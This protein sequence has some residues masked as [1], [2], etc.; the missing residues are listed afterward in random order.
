MTLSKVCSSA[1]P[2]TPTP[3]GESHPLRY[4]SIPKTLLRSATARAVRSGRAAGGASS[5]VQTHESPLRLLAQAPLVRVGGSKPR[6]GP[7]PWP[8]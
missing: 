1:V 5:D 3:R 8:L 2:T 7:R 4:M 6:P